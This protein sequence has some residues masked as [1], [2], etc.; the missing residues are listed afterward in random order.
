M[1]IPAD[2]EINGASVEVFNALGTRVRTETLSGSRSSMA[3]LPT[4][5]VYTIKITDR[6]GTTHFVKLVVK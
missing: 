2:I 4:A 5:G 6:N 1:E 3:G